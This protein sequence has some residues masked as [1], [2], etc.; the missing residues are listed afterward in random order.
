MQALVV[1]CDSM[2]AALDQSYR[3]CETLARREAGNFYP[4]F[5][6]LPKDQRRAMCALYAFMRIADDLSDEPGA[7]DDKRHS[8]TAWRQ[9]L[10]QALAGTSSHPIHPALQDVVA[11]FAVPAEYLEA[12][13]DGVEMDLTTFSYAT[14]AD[15]RLYCWRVASAV[16]LACIH[17]WGFRDDRAKELAENAGIAFQL[18]NI[19]RD[20]KEDAAR[21]RVYLPAEDLAR[22]G[23]D[24][25]RLRHGVRD[26]A[27]RA[28]MRFQ[29]ERAR[30][31]YERA[32]PLAP[33]L[34]R[35]GR[36]VFLMMAR[37][38][39]SLLNEMERRDYDVFTRRIRI[40]R[41]RKLMLALSVLPVRLGWKS[42]PIT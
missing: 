6:L 12:V 30:S 27:F 19:L 16:G 33:L 29:V 14:F 31:Y 23:Y 4:A 22:F 24:E 41:W 11:K 40:G 8:L 38:Y 42:T 15:L 37:T 17:L 10:R 7:V 1:K 34:D 36:A 28:L 9:A 3:Y 26:E 18:T 2:D 35:P 5:R 32:R 21:G 20:L 39:E 25:V 13:I